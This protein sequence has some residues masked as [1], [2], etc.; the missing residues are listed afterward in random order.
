[1][2]GRVADGERRRERDRSFLF[3]RFHGRLPELRATPRDRARSALLLAHHVGIFGF[4][5]SASRYRAAGRR[6]AVAAR[7]GA[8][9]ARPFTRHDRFR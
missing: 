6:I 5:A 9:T 1:M 7:Y 4:A 2:L 8:E 3:T